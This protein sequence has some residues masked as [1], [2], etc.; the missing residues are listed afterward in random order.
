MSKFVLF[1]NEASDKGSR[2][3]SARPD[4][5]PKSFQYIHHQP[6][7]C[8]IYISY[9]FVAKTVGNNKNLCLCNC[10]THTLEFRKA[11]D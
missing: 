3:K 8:L 9:V 11:A 6:K 4:K 1:P 5:G 2:I 10:F 7:E